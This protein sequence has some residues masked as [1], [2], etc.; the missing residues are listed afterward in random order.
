MCA[1]VVV[2]PTLSPTQFDNTCRVFPEKVTGTMELKVVKKYNYTRHG[3]NTD[4]H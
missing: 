4:Q 2:C 1:C 3:A